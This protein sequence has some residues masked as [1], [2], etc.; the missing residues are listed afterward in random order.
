MDFLAT[1]FDRTPD[2]VRAILKRKDID[3]QITDL[4]RAVDAI[5]DAID[6]ES[7]DGDCVGDKFTINVADGHYKL[8]RSDLEKNVQ[9]LA[10]LCPGKH[11]EHIVAALEFTNY[12]I[13]EAAVFLIG[14]EDPPSNTS[15][16]AADFGLTGRDHDVLILS[17]MFPDIDLGSL[18]EVISIEGGLHK[19]IQYLAGLNET[20]KGE[21]IKE[22]KAPRAYSE[23]ALS[24]KSLNYNEPLIPIV[25][26]KSPSPKLKS[27]STKSKPPSKEILEDSDH[28]REK[29]RQCLKLRNAA[30]HSAA[31]SYGKG[32]LT[33]YGSAQYYS[34]QGIKMSIH[35]PSTTTTDSAMQSRLL[36]SYKK[37]DGQYFAALQ[38][39]Q[40]RLKALIEDRERQRH[41]HAGRQSNM[42]ASFKVYPVPRIRPTILPEEALL[43]AANKTE[44]LVP[45]RLD[46]E[47]EGVKVRDVFTWNINDLKLPPSVFA[48]P[49]AKAIQE[50]LDEFHD[51][52]PLSSAEYEG[53]DD[54]DNGERD[55][56]E[57]RIL[58]KLDIT[59]SGISLVD[60]FEWDINCHRNSPE[61]F[62]EQLVTE[63]GLSAEFKSAICH[64][65]REQIQSY[66]KSLWLLEHPFD[67]SYIDDD[68]LAA[69]FLPPISQATRQHYP[70]GPLLLL[71]R[72]AE[73]EKTEKDRERDARRKR[74]QTGR[75]R[76][77]LP[78]REPLKTVRGVV[79][80]AGGHVNP[81]NL[82]KSTSGYLGGGHLRR[83]TRS[84]TASE[85]VEQNDGKDSL[86][87][88]VV[89]EKLR[90]DVQLANW[91]CSHCNSTLKMTSLARSGPEG[92]ASLCNECG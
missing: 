28:Y 43:S 40:V 55:N 82:R 91:S 52:R 68:E 49:I 21:I 38:Q 89:L 5:L 75:H 72:E 26:A 9:I 76:R 1:A 81:G 63:L 48:V 83:K 46:L 42:N 23:A 70:V 29:A 8:G 16:P 14:L 19:A 31:S 64:S 4:D 27:K 71:G 67:D 69:S 10:E 20:P 34:D 32:S 35:P 58:I 57:L 87:P 44:S 88:E 65:I 66:S 86:A 90:S 33:G 59:I 18:R 45:V 92:E 73:V 25:F 78:E 36:E 13:D 3:I 77:V 22:T 54:C 80:S 51:H 62:A 37:R 53:N 12:D 11:K 39:Q 85:L 79:S 50:Q 15:P 30:F 7:D 24:A 2:E 6:G 84:D 56:K 61:L 47:V 41:F 17:E 74:R 60:E